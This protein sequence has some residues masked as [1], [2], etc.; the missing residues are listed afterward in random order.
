[1]RIIGAPG[2]TRT[3]T[4]VRELAVYHANNQNIAADPGFENQGSSTVSWP[5]ALQGAGPAGI[6]RGLG[7]AHSGA[8][9]AYIRQGGTAWNALTQTVNVTPN[10]NYR[11]TGWTRTSGNVNEAYFGIRPGVSEFPHAEIRF[12][13][14]GG[15]TPLTVNFNSGSNSTMTIFAGYWVQAQIPGSS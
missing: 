12:G 5:W 13:P 2:G 4:S 6:D 10:T 8:N 3:F 11:L 14:Q 9:N 15:Y 1:M 7:F